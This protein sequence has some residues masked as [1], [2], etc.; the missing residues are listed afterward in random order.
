MINPYRLRL[1]WQC[2]K[3]WIPS[4]LQIPK[5]A[6]Q[7]ALVDSDWCFNCGAIL[8]LHYFSLSLKFNYYFLIVLDSS[9]PSSLSSKFI[10][11]LPLTNAEFK[12]KL[13]NSFV[14]SN[15]KIGCT[16]GVGGFWLALW[17]R[18]YFASAL[19]QFVI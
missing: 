11:C 5:L 4:F 17:L 3:W 14:S 6:A 16:I 15:P 19:F 7:L 2:G 12:F 1:R 18:C 8:P 9:L 10:C 13:M